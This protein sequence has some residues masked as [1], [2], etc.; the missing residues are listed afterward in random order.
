L[1]GLWRAVVGS[2]GS[3]RGEIEHCRGTFF[4]F[5]GVMMKTLLRLLLGWVVV[6]GLAGTAAAQGR[7]ATVALGKVFEG[8]W[9]TKQASAAIEDR[10]KELEK[11][12]TTMVD[13]WKRKKEEYQKQLA[14]AEDP[15]VSSEERDKRKKSA[16]AK[17]K[18][19]K[20]LEETIGQFERQARTTL[21]EQRLRRRNKLFEDIRRVINAKSKAAGYAL[22]IDTAAVTPSNL[23]IVLYNAGDNDI[24]DAALQ[25][26]NTDA[27][28]DATR[29]TGK[30]ADAKKDDTKKEEKK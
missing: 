20:E 19:I 10:G 12:H 23:P 7:T 6:I 2:T 5:T 9:K 24:T 30:P 21:D 22:V 14:S 25:T 11:E 28:T 8:Y 26:L 27:P 15:A 16:E 4:W 13:D 17:L 29:A 18:E 3:S 1:N